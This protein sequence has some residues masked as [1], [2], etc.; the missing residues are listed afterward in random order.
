MGFE[1]NY[2][3]LSLSK[4]RH[5]YRSYIN[6]KDS[7]L[8]AVDKT[9]LAL[10]T[11]LKGG[12]NFNP[13]F[14]T[15]FVDGEG[16]FHVSITENTNS[17]LG[18]RVKVIFNIVQNEKEKAMLEQIREFFAVGHITKQGLQAIQLQVQSFEKLEK[19]LKHFHK[20]PLMTKKCS[21]LKL[22]IM[23]YEIVR[24]KEHLTSEGL[25]KI[26][27]IKASMNRG[28]SEKLKLYF[29]HVVP[30]VRPIVE[31]PQIL[32]PNW[33]AGF[34]SAEGCFMVL[35]IASKTHSIGFLVRLEFRLAQHARDEEL[36][37]SLIE[38]FTCGNIY[39]YREVFNFRVIKFDDIANKII[40]FFL[41]YPIH[42]VKALDFKD[43]CLVA[44]MMK[45]KKHLTTDGLEKIRKI[46]A[47][48]NRGRNLR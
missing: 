15:G 36:M 5:T 9:N 47:G 48:M 22:F 6:T 7:L 8:Q 41:K 25:M 24:R 23:V 21:D 18:W 39:K 44:E 26:L 29:P 32:D 16:S 3:I 35:T 19:V 43:F 11:S 27:A 46:K 38:F 2:Q 4:Q 28:L 31:N 20:F 45:E 14:V 42:G 13:W 12:G 33:L 17:N 30:V 40:P 34:T 10:T 1:R 37:R